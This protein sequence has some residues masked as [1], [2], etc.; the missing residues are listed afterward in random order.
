MSRCTP[1][2]FR[3]EEEK[4]TQMYIET[5]EDLTVEEFVNK[6]ASEGYKKYFKE[7]EEERDRLLAEGIIVD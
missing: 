6:Y 4:I 1:L 5:E 3:A 2:K 7:Y